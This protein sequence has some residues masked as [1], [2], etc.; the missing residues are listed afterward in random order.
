M[1]K[2]KLKVH[3]VNY[4]V[5]WTL[6]TNCPAIND[7]PKRRYTRGNNASNCRSLF[8]V[9]RTNRLDVLYAILGKDF[10]ELAV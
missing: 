4:Y 8:L 5:L 7:L 3:G 6:F 2:S 10:A 9:I 1:Q